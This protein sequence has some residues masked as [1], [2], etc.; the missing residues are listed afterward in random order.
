M[1][2]TNRNS[3]MEPW[4]FPLIEEIMAEKIFGTRDASQFAPYAPGMSPGIK[5]LC[6]ISALTNLLT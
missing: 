6:I 1:G 4:I 5:R 2:Q 3:F